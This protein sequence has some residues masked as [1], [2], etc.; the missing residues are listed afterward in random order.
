[1]DNFWWHGERY[2]Y[3][4]TCDFTTIPVKATSNT[5]RGRIVCTKVILSFYGEVVAP[6]ISKK[7][8][9]EYQL[10]SIENNT[11]IRIL[12]SLNCVGSFFKSTNGNYD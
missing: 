10:Y 3:G 12:I 7:M 6:W 1:M 5:R 4:T 9:F 2:I 11:D 8:S